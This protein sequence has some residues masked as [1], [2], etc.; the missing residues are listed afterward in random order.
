M[1][2]GKYHFSEHDFKEIFRSV[3]GYTAP[4]F[5]FSLQNKVENALFGKKSNTSGDYSFDLYPE[6]REYNMNGVPFYALNNNG[7]EVYMPV[8]LIKSDGTRV[9]LQNTVMS[10]TA[11]NTIIETPLVNRKGNV[12]EEISI[13]DWDINIK[14]IIVST[15][16]NYPDQEVFELNELRESGEALGIENART[17]LLLDGS[18]KAVIKRLAFPALKGMQ[19]V[20]AFEMDLTSD[21]EF[22]LIIE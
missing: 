1:E 7:N 2:T 16:M 5:L 11:K 14:G 9:L 21:L 10:L 3:W 20:Q 17:S 8:W 18:E 13:D 12:K 4:P 22:S 15:D 19:H 6:R